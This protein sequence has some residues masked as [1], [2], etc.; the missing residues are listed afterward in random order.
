MA[1]SVL[2]RAASLRFGRRDVAASGRP[3]SLPRILCV[4]RPTATRT[5]RSARTLDRML[6]AKRI[7]QWKN[8]MALDDMHTPSIMRRTGLQ[9]LLVL[10]PPPVGTDPLPRELF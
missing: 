10:W 6:F 3:R 4:Q 7:R 1:I 5:V 2:H 9:Y 8:A